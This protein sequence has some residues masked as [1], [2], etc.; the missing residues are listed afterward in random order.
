MNSRS[1]EWMEELVLA[2]TDTDT[3]STSITTIWNGNITRP[4]ILISSGC[5]ALSTESNISIATRGN[6]SNPPLNSTLPSTSTEFKFVDEKE[7]AI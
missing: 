2:D 7:E 4:N 3:P 1:N 5:P 6:I